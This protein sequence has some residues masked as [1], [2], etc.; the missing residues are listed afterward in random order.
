MRE[1]GRG[2]ELMRG[3]GPET[4]IEGSY[5]S[6]FPWAFLEEYSYDPPVAPE[7]TKEVRE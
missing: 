6:F 3:A 2:E 7:S 5:E 4:P 1:V